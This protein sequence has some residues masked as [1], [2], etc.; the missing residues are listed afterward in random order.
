MENASKGKGRAINPTIHEAEQESQRLFDE[1]R[2]LITQA[3][4][5]PDTAK[6]RAL[7]QRA[8]E[9]FAKSEGLQHVAARLTSAAVNTNV[10]R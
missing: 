9:L 3:A 1:S 7:V 5:E 10:V 4:A 2:D 8:G 6:R